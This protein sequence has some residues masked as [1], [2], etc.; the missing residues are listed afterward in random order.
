M[1]IRSNTVRTALIALLAAAAAAALMV[2][3]FPS[4]A[5]TAP[6]QSSGGIVRLVS[7][8]DMDGEVSTDTESGIPI[9]NRTVVP[10]STANTLF[11]TFSG[12]GDSHDGAATR[13][14]CRVDGHGCPND[15]KLWTKV[16]KFEF[17]CE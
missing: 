10:P 3:L 2:L 9:F 6:A 13:L 12:T 14:G 16:Q 1:S 4:S 15:D 11:I 5:T 17:E 7:A 8:Y